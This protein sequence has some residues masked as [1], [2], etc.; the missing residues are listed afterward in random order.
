MA[1]SGK[2][3]G[4]EESSSSTP[5]ISLLDHVNGF[6]YNA[7]KKSDNFVIDM[8]AFSHGINKDSTNNANSRI[9]LQ[10]SLSRKGSQ[11]GGCGAEKKSNS[12]ANDRDATLAASSPRGPGTP[13]KPAGAAIG[14]TDIPQVHHQITITTGNI[15]T[16]PDSKSGFKRNSLKR[17]SHSWAIDPKRVL[18][19]FA[20]LWVYSPNF[21]QHALALE[22]ETRN[23]SSYVCLRQVEP[24]NNSADILHAI[25][26]AQC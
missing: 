3:C 16:T 13:E 1:S 7:L 4:M 11:R 14:S 22:F 17:S 25:L 10:K 21:Y 18:L 24:G 19:F 5:K 15:I 20:T 12:N 23:K 9:T 2:A 8:D 26:E 6:H